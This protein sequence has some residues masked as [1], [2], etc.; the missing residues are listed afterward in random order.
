MRIYNLYG[1]LSLA[2]PISI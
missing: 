1:S 2:P